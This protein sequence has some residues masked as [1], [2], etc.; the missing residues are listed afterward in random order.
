[1]PDASNRRI[2]IRAATVEVTPA[3]RTLRT[4]PPEVNG[5]PYAKTSLRA[6]QRALREKMRELGMSHR[7]LAVE[8]A[9]RYQLRPRAA[10]RNA[11][12]WSLTQA[13]EQINTYAARAGLDNG[14][15]VAMTAAHLSEHENWPG[16]GHRLTGRRPTPYLLSLLAAVYGCAVQELLDVADYEHMPAADRLILDKTSPGDRWPAGTVASPAARC[17]G[18]QLIAQPPLPVMAGADAQA[19]PAQPGEPARS[20]GPGSAVAAGQVPAAMLNQ[21][22]PSPRSRQQPG[23]WLA[24]GHDALAGALPVLNPDEMQHIAAALENAR[25]YADS[26]VAG[27]FRDQLAA[28]AVSDGMR[29]PKETL[30]LVLAVIAAIEHAAR[31]ARPAVRHDLMAVLAR[32]AEFAGWL[33][34]DSAALR[35]AGYWHDRAVEWAQMAGET[36]LQGYVLLKKSQAAWD[37]RDAPR[38]LMLAR[39]ARQ[40]PWDLPPWV[41]AEAIQQEARAEAMLGGG[42]T[43]I[44]ARLDEARGLLA[45]AQPGSTG[46]RFTLAA[47]YGT[48]LLAMQTAICYCEAGQPA[49]AAE[50]YGEHLAADAFSWRDYG[51]FRALESLAVASAG[52]PDDAAAIGRESLGIA[53][54]TGSVRTF[55]ELTR[56]MERLASWPGRPEVRVFRAELAAGFS[57]VQ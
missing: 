52:R 44:A 17:P 38:M 40:G 37:E 23:A 27:Y 39:A 34:R 3:A 16:Q 7:Q 18:G 55:T 4:S 10:W 21:S 2:M 14:A 42:I 36:A 35:L 6:E 9:R 48:A 13:A 31:E 41:Q 43:V 49:R 33:Y 8:F 25:R 12:G 15:T 28:Y 51:Y 5:M 50:I 29:G 30:P 56:L 53:A 54:A 46:D 45:Q 32:S 11:Y 47:H 22:D 26:T 24:A 20:R 19:L 1:L 57:R